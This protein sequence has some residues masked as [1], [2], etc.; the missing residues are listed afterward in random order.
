MVRDLE[1]RTHEGMLKELGL[2]DIKR[3]RP[4]VNLV[5]VY[6]TGGCREDETRPFLQV[7]TKMAKGN[8]QKLKHGELQL[9]IRKNN[10]FIIDLVKCWGRA[11]K[12]SGTCLVL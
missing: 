6:L 11:Q 4:R 1:H 8:R 2:H 3:R 7:S 9:K 5:A 10:K 12:D